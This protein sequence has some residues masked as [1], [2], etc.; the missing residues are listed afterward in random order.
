M[1]VNSAGK[2]DI[3]NLVKKTELSKN[4]LNQLSKNVK[5]ISTKALAKDFIN[6]FS[7]FNRAKY[8]SWGIFQ[9]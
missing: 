2:N 4:E 1:Q 8:F 9:Y 7:V 5:A 6:K 3:S